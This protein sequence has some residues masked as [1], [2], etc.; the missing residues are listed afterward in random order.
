MKNKLAGYKALLWILAIPVL[1]VFY[2]ILNHGNGN[3][4]SLWT[5][6]DDRIP[7]VPIFIIPY[8]LWYP[9][10]LM[11]LVALFMKKASAY[12]RTLIALCLGLLVSYAT[13]YFF[14]TMITRPDAS[15]TGVFLW[16]V[17]LV[18]G[19]DG[20]YNC[21]PS[22]HVLTSYLM[23]K[24]MSECRDQF[25]RASRF[26]IQLLSWS[27]TIS[28]VF[29]KQHVL[30]DIIGGIVVAEITFFAAGKWLSKLRKDMLRWSP[31][32]RWLQTWEQRVF[33]WC[34]QSISHPVLSRVLAAMTHMG[35]ALFTLTCSL[36]ISLLA[37][38]PWRTAGIQSFAA[39][40]VSHL[41][42]VLMKKLIRRPRP[43][44]ALPDTNLILKPLKDHS[45]PS[46]H[47][48]AVFSIVV[49]FLFTLPALAIILLPLAA[50]VG[51]SRVY[52]GV[53]YPSDCLAGGLIGISCALLAV[54]LI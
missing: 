51:L 39:L 49:P 12:Y 38:E 9:F 4:S 5:S 46:G 24:G 15:G 53:H 32:W 45:F 34:N 35:G 10:V 22:I 30:L 40:A 48:T 29:V 31:F 36:S 54:S 17:R 14:Q 42:A 6:W 18:Y 41:A 7:F 43:Y 23:L 19:T 11:M 52:L 50:G 25:S 33:N 16:L 3:V 20:A 13:F 44:L 27:V 21:F 26:F 1:N 47:T 2:G 37:P 8:L 28:T